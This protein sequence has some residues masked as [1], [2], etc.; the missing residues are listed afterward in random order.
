MNT[1][2]TSIAFLGAVLNA[3][4][5]QPAGRGRLDFFADRLVKCASAPTLS[6]AIEHLLRSVDAQTDKV[7]PPLASH[8]AA[9]ANGPDGARVLR[10]WREQ[11]RLVTLI[12]AT[13]DQEARDAAI[14][15]LQLPASDRQGRASPRGQFKVALRVALETPL[16]HGSDEKTGNATLF[17][18]MQVLAEEG[19][20]LHLPYYAGNALRGHMR[21]LLADHFLLS[22]GL[23]ADRSQPVVALWFFYALYSGGALEENSDATKALRKQLGDHGAVRSPG[24]RTFRDRLPALSLLGCALGNR[25]LPGRCQFA[26]LRPV[27]HEWGTGER[28]VAELLTWEYLTRREDHE[29]HLV[30]HS[31]IADTELL[32]AG[33]ELEGGVDHDNAMPAIERAALG[34]GLALL[35]EQGKLGA[36]TRRG[37][38]RVR[39][40]VSDLPDPQPYDDYLSAN[41]RDILGYLGELGALADAAA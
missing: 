40:A 37:F 7:F 8:M 25:L 30:N 9:V 31:M 33:T 35:V 12:A 13:Q 3:M 19:G 39:I 36:A 14:A 15:E 6:G 18:R 41:M 10:W 24:I 23:R 5:I 38:G 1:I 32:R 4:Q 34:R 22:L 16:A 27:C 26:D 17:R 21:D 20:V 2:P 29:A 28:P 11:A